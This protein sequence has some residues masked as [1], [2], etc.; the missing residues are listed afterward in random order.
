[1]NK[2]ASILFIALVFFLFGSLFVKAEISYYKLE[3]LMAVLEQAKVIQKKI[4][5]DEKIAANN[6]YKIE[7]L[8][9]K[10]GESLVAGEVLHIRWDAM[11]SGLSKID[12]YLATSTDVHK[13]KNPGI[14]LA[15]EV[16]A[17]TLFYAWTVPR[18]YAGM[19][20]RILLRNPGKYK[21]HDY[22]DSDFTIKGKEETDSLVKITSIKGDETF[23][24]GRTKRVS[25]KMDIGGDR[26]VNLRLVR[27]DSSATSTYYIPTGFQEL[28]NSKDGAVDWV[29]PD[30]ETGEYRMK[31]FGVSSECPYC[32]E[33]QAKNLHMTESFKII[34]K[35]DTPASIKV[36]YPN[37]DNDI[38]LVVTKT[39][40][41]DVKLTPIGT[42]TPEGMATT[43]YITS[44]TTLVTYSTST[45]KIR[46]YTPL[47][48][49]HI[50]IS[51]RSVPDGKVYWIKNNLFSLFPVGS[52]TNEYE[53]E[54]DILS[55]EGERFYLRICRVNSNYCDE[56]DKPFSI[57]VANK[58]KK[59]EVPVEEPNTPEYDTLRVIIDK[60]KQI[61]G[62]MTSVDNNEEEDENEEVL[63]DN[64]EQKTTY[65]PYNFNRRLSYGMIDDDGVR[66]LQEALKKEG[67]FDHEVTGR[68]FEVTQKAVQDFQEKYGFDTSG[69]V[70][71]GTQAKLNELYG[72][73]EDVLQ[74]IEEVVGEESEIEPN[75]EE[76]TQVES[77]EEQQRKKLLDDLMSQ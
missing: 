68:F 40:K 23:Y 55:E 58:E 57:F 33:P 46:W 43:T 44:T 25:W 41:T 74:M 2:K 64:F 17:N 20:F 9:P 3:D 18:N 50:D 27:A 15:K 48:I 67:F 59:V 56:S 4:I 5:E 52:S 69:S 11:S 72:T 60:V 42:T 29:I 65:L 24:A 38:E 28:I 73:K 12:I 75:E 31:I 6:P 26:F 10:G 19:S 30:I 53:W 39:E 45:E 32:L 77:E 35:K 76:M 8:N 16:P 51:L 34:S 63:T 49:D 7:V 21:L 70:G 62:N 14:L 13:L 54:P 1:M 71:P 61:L 22:S 66:A 47:D 36:V 37:G